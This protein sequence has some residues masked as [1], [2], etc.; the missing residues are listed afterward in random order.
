MKKGALYS[1]AVYL[2]VS[3]EDEDIQSSH[4]SVSNSIASQR[5]LTCSFVREQ[6]DMELFEVYIDDGYSGANFV[7]VR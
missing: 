2:R 6:K 4:K 7:E 1:A 5:E 3:K